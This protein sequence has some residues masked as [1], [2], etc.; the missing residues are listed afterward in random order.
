MM[1]TAPI[2]VA[3]VACHAYLQ[4][5]GA[6]LGPVG[7][8]M[9]GPGTNEPRGMNGMAS[10]NG[11][12]HSDDSEGRGH[13]APSKGA[14]QLDREDLTEEQQLD[15]GKRD[16]S[17]KSSKKSKCVPRPIAWRTLPT[18]LLTLIGMLSLVCAEGPGGGGGVAC[19]GAVCKAASAALCSAAEELPVPWLCPHQT[20]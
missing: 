9:R 3:N 11:N 5:S 17:A 20:A 16:L 7:P 12:A 15:G 1:E 10:Q 19:C 8:A 2:A 18:L 6:P 14:S 13:K 4:L